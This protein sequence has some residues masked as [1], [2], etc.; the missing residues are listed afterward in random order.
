MT[1]PVATIFRRLAIEAGR[2]IMKIYES[3]DFGVEAKAD[4]S[5]VTK[6]DLAADKVI[7]AGLKAALPDIQIKYSYL[8]TAKDVIRHH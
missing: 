8:S 3:D 2:E 6:A 7:Y 1:T 4:E 5:P